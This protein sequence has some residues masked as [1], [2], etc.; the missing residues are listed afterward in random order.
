MK[1]NGNSMVLTATSSEFSNNL[2]IA[3]RLKLNLKLPVSTSNQ[4][5]KCLRNC[6]PIQPHLQECNRLVIGISLNIKYKH[7]NYLYL[8]HGTRIANL[9]L[10]NNFLKGQKHDEPI[11][12]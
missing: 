6:K 9:S 8:N 3:P 1:N 7:S 12:F 4:P 2:V 11:Y 10:N 5:S